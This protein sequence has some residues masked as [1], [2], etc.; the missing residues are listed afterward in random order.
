M[1]V[2]LLV[3]WG[4]FMQRS[5]ALGPLAVVCAYVMLDSCFSIQN[6]GEVLG[7]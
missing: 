6:I 5:T 3:E 7:L 2:N 1:L 4:L